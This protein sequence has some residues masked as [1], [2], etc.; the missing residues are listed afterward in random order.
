[1]DGRGNDPA[2]TNSGDVENKESWPPW[3]G[4]MIQVVFNQ[5][6]M[7]TADEVPVTSKSRFPLRS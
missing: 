7:R 5:G 3:E 6:V 2:M 1:M 4:A